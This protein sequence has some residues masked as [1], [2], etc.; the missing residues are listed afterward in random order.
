M[1]A[2]LVGPRCW[3]RDGFTVAHGEV[4]IR[5]LHLEAPRMLSPS[6]AGRPTRHAAP[7]FLALPSHPI[8]LSLGRLPRARDDRGHPKVSTRRPSTIGLS[9]LSRENLKVRR[10]LASRR[11]DLLY[12]SRVSCHAISSRP[13][14]PRCAC[15]WT[16][17]SRWGGPSGAVQAVLPRD[18]TSVTQRSPCALGCSATSPVDHCG[19]G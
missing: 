8:F 10:R 15:A 6:G 13:P 5:L 9:R 12:V 16:R 1:A 17:C 7:G 4:S 14:C 19:C 2:D 11:C 3:P 18:G